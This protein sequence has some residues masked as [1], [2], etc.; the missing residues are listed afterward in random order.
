MLKLTRHVFGWTADAAAADYYERLLWNGVLGTQHPADGD[1][2]YYVPLASGYWK[3]FGTPLHDFW[4]CTGTGSESAAKFGDSIWFHDDDG[5]WV[6]QFI[7]SE[8]DWQEKG[9]HLVQDTRF[10]AVAGTAITVRTARPTRFALRVRVP[11]WTSGGG[12]ALD[13]RALDGFA[14]PGGWFVLD[15]VWHDGDRLEVALPMAL[16]LAPMPD[17]A[18][19]QAVMYGP[20]VLVGKLGSDGIT[21]Q[22]RRAEPTRPGRVPEFHDQPPAAP[23]LRARGADP[24]AWIQRVSAADQPPEFRTSGQE[25]DVALVPFHTL[26][27]ERYAVYWKFAG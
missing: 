17:D 15:R 4:C 23:T 2:L 6:A 12:A 3:L 26:Y 19:V 8:L 11:G 10:P 5:V 13:G 20:L 7:A 14:A 21:D 16:H 18:T 1:K 27:D 25:R 9:V 22:N 24:A